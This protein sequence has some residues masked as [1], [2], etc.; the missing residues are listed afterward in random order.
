MKISFIIVAF[1]AAGSLNALLEDLLAQTIPH[2]QI[3]ALLVDSA[4]TD[5]TRAIMLDFANAAPFEV[6]VLNPEAKIE[7]GVDKKSG[8]KYYTLYYEG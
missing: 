4:S 7:G 3:E 8:K 5:A 1:N 2:E 6:K